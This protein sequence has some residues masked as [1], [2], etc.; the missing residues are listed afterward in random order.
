VR[1][2]ALVRPRARAAALGRRLVHL[3]NRGTH[4]VLR[5]KRFQRFQRFQE[6]DS[7]RRVVLS[8]RAGN[9]RRRDAERMR[10]RTREDAKRKTKDERHARVAL[11]RL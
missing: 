7:P 8:R 3:L 10:T 6:K 1:P 2:R 11:I 4:G 9:E 5:T